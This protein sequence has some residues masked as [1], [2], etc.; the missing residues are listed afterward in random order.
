MDLYID[1]DALESASTQL[2]G[3][4]EELR[5]LKGNIEKSFEQLKK[6]WN[7][8]AGKA[9]FKKFEENLLNSL[10]E[11]VTVFEYMSQNLSTASEQYDE[12]FRDADALTD[13]EY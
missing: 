12:V 5:T 13:Q 7:T 9:F 10:D 4:C 1:K 6:D 3:K 8:D 2:S 11:Y